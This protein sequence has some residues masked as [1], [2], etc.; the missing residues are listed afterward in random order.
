MKKSEVRSEIISYCFGKHDS[1]DLPVSPEAAWVHISRP[2]KDLD[3]FVEVSLALYTQINHVSYED[4][5]AIVK[6]LLLACR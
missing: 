3:V 6:E 2:S 5:V 4:R 1:V